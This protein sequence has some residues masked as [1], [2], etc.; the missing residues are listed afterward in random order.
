MQPEDRASMHKRALVK[1]ETVNKAFH[2]GGD[3]R[4]N[5]GTRSPKIL[6]GGCWT[7]DFDVGCNIK[8]LYIRNWLCPWTTLG[9]PPP[10]PR[11]P[12]IQKKSPPLHFTTTNVLL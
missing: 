7:A 4:G 9:A 5:G 8:Q 3:Y 2:R 11:P 1:Y 6:V 12:A 10:D